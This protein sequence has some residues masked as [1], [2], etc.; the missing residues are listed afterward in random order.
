MT[1]WQEPL[2]HIPIAQRTK[3]TFQRKAPPR[4][5]CQMLIRPNFFWLQ[6]WL[7]GHP[8]QEGYYYDCL[9]ADFVVMKKDAIKS[10]NSVSSN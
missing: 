7:Q 8:N 6:D 1:R 2:K 3:E 9:I 4:D 10:K 5:N